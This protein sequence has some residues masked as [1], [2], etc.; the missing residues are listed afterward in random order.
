MIYSLEEIAGLL[1]PILERYHARGASILAHTLEVRR[2]PIQ[3]LTLS[4]M[5][6]VFHRTDVFSIAEDLFDASGKRV[7]V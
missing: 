4:S 6:P 3:I 5:G 2:P 1:R 7:D